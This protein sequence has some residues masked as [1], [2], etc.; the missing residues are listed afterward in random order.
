MWS[1]PAKTRPTSGLTRPCVSAMTPIFMVKAAYTFSLGRSF[2][3]RLVA[4]GLLAVTST[5]FAQTAEHDM[6]GARA[7]FEDN[8]AAIRERNRDKYLSYY[9]HSELLV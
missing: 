3:R 1:T 5:L 2:M 7:V 8:I 4:L 6:A 9:L